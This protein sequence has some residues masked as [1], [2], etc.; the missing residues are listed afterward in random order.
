FTNLLLVGA[1]ELAR[2]TDGLRL[3]ISH[4]AVFQFDIHLDL[5]PTVGFSNRS[6]N[7]KLVSKY[8]G[9]LRVPVGCFK[10]VRAQTPLTIFSMAV[11]FPPTIIIRHTHENP[12]KC[13][14]LPLRGRPDLIFLRHPVV[15]R[16]CL[17]GYVRLAAEGEELS[18]AD[19]ASGLLLLD[20]SWRWAGVM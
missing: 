10:S 2:Q 15:E 6:T 3:V 7:N 16:P 18:S 20:A 1:Q 11:L 5:L 19:A 13:S 14:V 9:I 4:R 12:R 17:E 8:I